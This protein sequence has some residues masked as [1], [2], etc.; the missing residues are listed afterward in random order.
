MS[1]CVNCGVELDASL[2]AC[3]LCNTPV[4]NPNEISYIKSKTPFP[5]E[6]GQV[7]EVKRKDLGILFS[8]LL[9]TI[10]ITCGLL[11]FLVFDVTRWSL[12]VIGVCM[13]LWVL[14]I[15][16]FINK[17]INGYIVLFFDG[18]AVALYLYMITYVTTFSNWFW[19]LALPITILVTVV[20]EILAVC[21]RKI[22]RSFLTNLLFFFVTV[23]VLCV[24]IEL[25]IDHFLGIKLWLTWSAVVLTVCVIIS[26]VLI[27]M[28]SQKRIRN[29]VRKRLHF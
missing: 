25:L 8:I 29:A 11:N 18:V 7:E 5:V 6:K 27:T 21:V 19:Y 16:L 13:L 1:Y 14:F 20:A 12:L 9:V 4:I 15:P 22:P 2:E 23:A 3:P 24:G 17:K 26:I 10:A 28:L